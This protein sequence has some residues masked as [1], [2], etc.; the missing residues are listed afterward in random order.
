MLRST[1]LFDIKIP[2]SYVKADTVQYFRSDF[3]SL[4]GPR[5]RKYDPDTFPTLVFTL[6]NKTSETKSVNFN[7]VLPK[8]WELI[9]YTAPDS[10]GPNEKKIS[11][12]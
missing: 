7:P 11:N 3:Y 9:N 2:E 5:Y 4:T 10:I 1:I 12:R 6:E 8:G